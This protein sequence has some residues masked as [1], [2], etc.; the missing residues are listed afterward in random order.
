MAYNSLTTATFTGRVGGAPSFNQTTSGTE[1]SNFDLAVSRY[2]PRLEGDNKTE[3]MWVRVTVFGRQAEF[4]DDKVKKGALVGVSG[5]LWVRQYTAKD[6][7]KGFSTEITANE[8]QILHDV[9]EKPAQR[10]SDPVDDEFEEDAREG[11]AQ[12]RERRQD[13]ARH[14]GTTRQTSRG[15]RSASNR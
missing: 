12:E 8:V 6:G 13:A 7:S 2:N 3:T 10:R 15:S 14:N 1:I 9:E 11:E 4:V 5:S